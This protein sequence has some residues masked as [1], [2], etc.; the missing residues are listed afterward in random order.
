MIIEYCQK[1]IQKAP[2]INGDAILWEAYLELG[3][4]YMQQKDFQKSLNIYKKAVSHL[5]RIRSKIQLEELKASYFGTGKKI[6]TYNQL[7]NLLVK[8]DQK[9]PG[10]H[11][12]A[13]AFHYLE[14]AKARAFLD[15]LEVSQIGLTQ[16]IDLSLLRQEEDLKLY[17]FIYS[18][19]VDERI[20][21]I[22]NSLLK[23]DDYIGTY[24][25][26]EIGCNTG[27]LIKKGKQI[28]LKMEVVK[29]EQ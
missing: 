21:I 22:N 17:G 27:G 20:A 19:N 18:L 24:R 5:E 1:A 25:G 7:I 23:I 3:N 16:N 29:D 13:E 14:K 28:I 9:E 11:Y 2:K 8:L 15:R 4:A 26:K 10:S 6:D 12:D